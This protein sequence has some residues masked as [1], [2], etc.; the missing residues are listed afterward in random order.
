[1]EPESAAARA[2]WLLAE[3]ARHNRLY[4]S[5][6]APEITDAEF[7]ALVRELRELEVSQPEL[8]RADS[9]TQGVGSAPSA[10]FAIVTHATPM[11]SLDNAMDHPALADFD[12]RVMRGLGADTPVVYCAEPKLDGLAMSLLYVKGQFVRAATRGDGSEGEDVTANCAALA[13]IPAALPPGAP[14]EIEVR[15]ELFMT[16]PGFEALNRR[17][18]AAG[19]KRFVNPRN[20]AAGSVRTLD[21]AVTASRPLE[22]LA[23]GAVGAA[24]P[25][26]ASTQ[27]GLLDALAALGFPVSE[28]RATVSGFEGARAYFD[29]LE[30][31]RAQVDIPMDG[32]VFKVDRFDQQQE[33]GFVSRAPRWAVARK[34]PPEEATTRVID[35]IVNVGRTGA[36]TPAAQLEPVFVGG[37]TVSNATLHNADEIGRL[38]VRVGDSVVVRRAGDVIPE[39]VRVLFDRRPAD[40]QP[41]E[42]PARCP[43]CGT[44]VSRVEGEVVVRCPASASCPAQRLESLL[45]FVSR[46]AMD[47]DGFGEKLLA[48]LLDTGRVRDVADLFTLTRDDLLSLERVGGKL[49][50]RLI[51]NLEAARTTTLARFINALGIREVGEATARLLAESFGDI[52]PLMQADAAT[53]EQ[54]PDIGP[55]VAA[56]IV[57]HFAQET[58]R[59]LVRRL[60]EE[61]GVRWPVVEALPVGEGPLAGKSVVITGSFSLGS[62]DELR[63]RLLA[64]GAKVGDSVSRKTSYVAA[65]ESPGSK[66]E[67]ARSLGV[68]VLDEAALASLLASGALPGS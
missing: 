21:P 51:H 18:D 19:E 14:E 16:W 9:P 67:K 25:R 39:V 29:A 45:H 17:Q 26:L 2:A 49:A 15:G 44:P 52:D 22:F 66:L 37:A 28:L 55:I 57:E 59:E 65:G 68:P 23:Y 8:A 54:L 31:R 50:D 64:L 48:Q 33:L 40:S 4:F 6:D 32:C 3:I 5:E 24:V 7:D 10:R 63:A 38:D 1:M 60:R 53:L 46:R 13:C 36:L 61:G 12:A 56:H 34:F 43:A 20:A 27:S 35:I 41:W 47:I 58:H 11:L 30:T 62:R 42:M